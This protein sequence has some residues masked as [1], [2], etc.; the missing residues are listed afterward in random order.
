MGQTLDPWPFVYG[1]YAI[2]VIGT[3][4]LVAWS[5]A[6]MRRAEQRREEARGR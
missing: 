4:I 2:G 5:W 3:A 6:S 1:A